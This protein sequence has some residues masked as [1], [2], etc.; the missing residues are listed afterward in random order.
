M[1]AL[2]GLVGMEGGGGVDFGGDAWRGPKDGIGLVLVFGA[3]AGKGLV[4][5]AA[6]LDIVCRTYVGYRPGPVKSFLT[7]SSNSFRVDGSKFNSQSKYWHMSHS[8]WFIS[9]SWNIPCPTMLHDL[10]E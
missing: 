4:D 8:I 2:A 10:F 1:Y 3:M 9:L 7:M 6:N 5:V